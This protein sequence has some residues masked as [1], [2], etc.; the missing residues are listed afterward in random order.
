MHSVLPNE[1]IWVL[2]HAITLEGY[3]GGIREV[4]KKEETLLPLIQN[5][6][7]EAYSAFKIFAGIA[8]SI[9]G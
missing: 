1:R 3:S 2:F 8:M 4:E 5:P 7:D 6:A 9:R